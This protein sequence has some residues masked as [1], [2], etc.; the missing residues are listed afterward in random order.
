MNLNTL[1]KVTLTLVLGFCTAVPAWAEPTNIVVRVI[2]R[3]AKFIG[4]S[5]GGAQVILR[6]AKTGEVFAE[7]KTSGGTGDTERLM[8]TNQSRRDTLSSEGAAEYSITLDLNEP[9]L[10]EVVAVGPLV[11]QENANR[12][13]AT[14]WVIPGKHLTGGDGWVLELPGF[15][16]DIQDIPAE[17]KMGGAAQR[18]EVRADVKMM[19]G[20]P[21]EPGGMWDADHY[22]IKAQLKTNGQVLGETALTYAGTP[23]QFLGSFEVA[24][25]GS[26]EIAVYAY[27]SHN[28]N[29]GLDTAIF[30]VIEE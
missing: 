17:L 3:D 19:C 30:E 7:G 25:S 14:Q 13:S 10:V 27:D 5:M 15:F 6:D 22:E 9:R 29:T 8:K 4:T 28:G 12:V 21:I 1:L 11:A 26:Y 18:I 16:I 2:S 23:S 24:M 20:C